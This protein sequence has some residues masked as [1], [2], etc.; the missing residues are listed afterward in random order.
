MRR[1]IKE[2]WYEKDWFTANDEIQSNSRK[3][4]DFFEN[5]SSSLSSMSERI[6]DNLESGLGLNKNI[7]IGL[8]KEQTILIPAIK[9]LIARSEVFEGYVSQYELLRTHHM[10]P[11]EFEKELAQLPESSAVG[12][13]FIFEPIFEWTY[14]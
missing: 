14:S 13:H 2:P 10:K 3:N 11:S 5:I 6:K 12:G 7:G 9:K 8:K 4:F 1:K